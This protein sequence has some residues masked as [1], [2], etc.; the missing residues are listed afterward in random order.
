LNL[1]DTAD[2]VVGHSFSGYE[3][4][5]RGL[6]AGEPESVRSYARA[7]PH[8]ERAEFERVVEEPFL[9]IRA[10]GSLGLDLI[11]LRWSLSFPIEVKASSEP[12]IRFSAASGR[13]NAQL[14]AH[15][16]SI[17][18]V[19]LAV[20]YA[21]RRIGCRSGEAWRL[22]LGSAPPDS[23]VLRLVCRD[24]PPVSVT[25]EG[26]GILRWEEGRPLSRFLARARS[27]LDRPGRVGS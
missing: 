10:A 2:A 21:Y 16:E 17:A 5:L 24:L 20:L 4:E 13:A 7:L 8:A 19:G 18:R 22:F 11:A 26:N 3:R 9:V 14:A 23:G 25:R 27:L 6:L 1:T 15:R 12:V